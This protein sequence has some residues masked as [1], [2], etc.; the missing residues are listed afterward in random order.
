MTETVL[1]TKSAQQMRAFRRTDQP[2]WDCFLKAVV[3][4]FPMRGSPGIGSGYVAATP[5][6]VA[7]REHHVVRVA[8][9]DFNVAHPMRLV[10][11]RVRRDGMV[12]DPSSHQ[13]RPRRAAVGAAENFVHRTPAGEGRG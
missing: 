8:G 1:V 11:A 10:H 7:G 13:R 2:L 9:T 4:E 5:D 3:E 6:A 12:P